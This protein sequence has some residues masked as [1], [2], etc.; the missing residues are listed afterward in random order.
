[1]VAIPVAIVGLAIAGCGTGGTGRPIDV[2]VINDS[3][4]TVELQPSCGVRCKPY[5]PADLTP[6]QQHTWH[7]VEGEP[8]I[9]SFGVNLP[10]NRSLGCLLER[11]AYRSADNLRFRVSN[12]EECVT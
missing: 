4:R 12:L 2:V 11:K 10:H 5:E 1:M 8:G 3:H 7:T 9:L 6:G